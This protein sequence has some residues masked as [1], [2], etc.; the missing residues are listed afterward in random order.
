MTFKIILMRVANHRKGAAIYLHILILLLVWFQSCM[1]LSCLI[2]FS[3]FKFKYKKNE[4]N[5]PFGLDV[6]EIHLFYA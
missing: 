6:N 5:T 4:A 1:S 3:F 2:G